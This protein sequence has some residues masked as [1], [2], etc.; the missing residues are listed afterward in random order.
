MDLGKW[1]EEKPRKTKPREKSEA[2]PSLEPECRP[3]GEA[4]PLCD[5]SGWQATCCQQFR[6][7]EGGAECTGN[8]GALSQT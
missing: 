6:Q 2:E 7:L 1:V 4:G 3:L 5:L 8:V